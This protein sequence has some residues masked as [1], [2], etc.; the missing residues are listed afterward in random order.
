MAR[1]S[2]PGS[3][4]ADPLAWGSDRTFGQVGSRPPSTTFTNP[5]YHGAD[6][7]VV[8]HGDGYFLCQANRAGQI[9]VW[10]SRSLTGRGERRV[11]WTP[12]RHGWNRAQVWAPELH[13]IGDEWYIYYAA[14][15]GRNAHHRM[16]VLQGTGD[17]P[18]CRFVDRGMLYTGDDCPRRGA[19]ADRRSNRWAID[20][21][22]LQ[23][24]GKLYFLWSGWQGEHDVQHLYIAPMSDPC[25]VSGARVRLVDNDC[26]PWERVA[27]CRGQRGLHEAPQVLVRNGRVMVVYSCS[28]S[29]EP[30]YKLGMLYMDESA[31]PTDRASWHKVTAPAFESTRDVFGVGH[32]CFTTSPDGTEDWIVYHA[33]TRR[34]HGWSDRVVR[35]QRFTWRADG[36]PNFGR[37]VPSTVPQVRPAGEVVVDQP[38]VATT[39]AAHPIGMAAAPDPAPL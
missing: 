26:H 38:A 31:D 20:G 1:L 19:P 2:G 25:T 6:P 27:E 33:K 11:V 39:G 18:Q 4:I 12:P 29:W 23:L 30:T 35:A 21:T 28:G 32:C 22:V 14:S 24:R 7:W 36:L 17:D 3:A 16:G 15:D 9:E 8:R 10:R 5:L 34:W 13:R 37:P